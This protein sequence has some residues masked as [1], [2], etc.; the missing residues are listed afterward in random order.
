MN[1]SAGG[2]NFRNLAANG[3]TVIRTGRG[4]LHTITINDAGASSNTCTVY[5]GTS[6]AGTVIATIDTVT[7]LFPT[8]LTFD[9]EFATGLTVVLATGTAAN[10]TV[11]WAPLGG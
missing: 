3:T 1:P 4:I 2:F 11:T 7:T 10:I 6:A 8:T 9:A 5:D